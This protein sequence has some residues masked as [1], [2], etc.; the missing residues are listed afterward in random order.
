M[1]TA[2]SD[3]LE[4]GKVSCANG[5]YDLSGMALIFKYLFSTRSRERNFY[6]ESANNMLL[7]HRTK[8]QECELKGK[9][10]GWFPPQVVEI[11]SQ[12]FLDPEMYVANLKHVVMTEVKGGQ[13]IVQCATY[14]V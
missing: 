11:L 8:G 5:V 2:R 14:V 1:P 6:H 4:E 9:V 7:R 13:S 12:G 10:P 3:Y